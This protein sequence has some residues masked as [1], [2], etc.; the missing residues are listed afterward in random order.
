MKIR[1]L[2]QWDLHPAEAIALQNE[3]APS[4]INDAPLEL[5]KIRTVAG[6]D[7]SVK[8]K[9]SRAAIVVMRYPEL[10]IIETVRA[11]QETSYPY[12]PGLLA[13]RE[14][15]VLVEA[16]RQ[17]RNQPDVFIFD[18]M[19][20]I[21]PRKM[22][23]AAHLGLW[24]QCPTI[25]CGKTH[26][27]GEYDEPTAQ[28]GSRSILRYRGEQLGIV[29]RSRDNVKPV[30]IS[31]GH[32]AEIDSAIELILSCTPKYRLPQPVRAAHKAAALGG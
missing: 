10:E 17:L 12:I 6:V 31:V 14:G 32:L 24:L 25:G 30:Y 11:Q 21:H 28:K 22:G 2:H 5:E 7:V 29:L 13:F 8:H 16:L 19:G 15:P 27:I 1:Q 26:F 18:G 20:Q 9:H 23:I 3:L 4:L